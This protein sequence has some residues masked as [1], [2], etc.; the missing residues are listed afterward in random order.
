MIELI[1]IYCSYPRTQK[2]Q[3]GFL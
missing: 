2:F 3:N 1:E